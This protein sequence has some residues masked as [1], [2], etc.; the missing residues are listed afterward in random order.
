EAGPQTD[1]VSLGCGLLTRPLTSLSPFVYSKF[2]LIF[3]WIIFVIFAYKVAQI[4][5]DYVTFDPF[6]ILGMSP[7]AS[8]AEIKKAYRRL[9]LIYH[10]DKETG[11]EKMF[12]RIT[13]AHAALTDEA[14]RKNWEEYGNPD[15]PGAMSFG[16]A[17]PSW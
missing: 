5:P 3:A 10:P 4:R 11:D 15:G 6:E 14:A 13:K 9:S 17:L 12:M 8:N 16:I 2:V 7:G 1:H